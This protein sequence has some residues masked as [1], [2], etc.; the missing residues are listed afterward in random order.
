M[1]LAWISISYLLGDRRTLGDGGARTLGVVSTPCFL[2]ILSKLLYSHF[3]HDSLAA[4]Y[5]LPKDQL[6]PTSMNLAVIICTAGSLG[7]SS[8]VGTLLEVAHKGAKYLLV[9]ADDSFRFPTAA[10]LADSC[11]GSLNTSPEICYEMIMEFFKSI[12]VVFQPELYSSTESVLVTKAQEIAQRLK[13][14]AALRVASISTGSGSQPEM[15]NKSKNDFSSAKVPT[16]ETLDA[17]SLGKQD[18]FLRIYER[19]GYTNY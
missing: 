9:L 4:P 8:Y 14:C 18:D 1:D 17:K 19:L 10:L 2:H 5:V 16:R 6:V 15:P 12:A 13:D 3:V 11:S 7:S